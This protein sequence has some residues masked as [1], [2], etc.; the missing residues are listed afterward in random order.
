MTSITTLGGRLCRHELGDS[1]AQTHNI[2]AGF[3]YHG[4][5]ATRFP[6]DRTA[7]IVNKT[8]ER[9]W[10]YSLELGI[11]LVPEH[12]LSTRTL[13]YFFSCASGS[14]HISA[15]CRRGAAQASSSQAKPP[16]SCRPELSHPPVKHVSMTRQK[17]TAESSAFLMVPPFRDH[18]YRLYCTYICGSATPFHFPY[19][20]ILWQPSTQRN[21]TVKANRNVRLE[22]IR[23]FLKLMEARAR[24]STGKSPDGPC[25]YALFLMFFFPVFGPLLPR[26]VGVPLRWSVSLVASS[27]WGP[28]FSFSCRHTPQRCWPTP[29]DTQTGNARMLPLFLLP[30]GAIATVLGVFRKRP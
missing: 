9:H 5:G 12:D 2:G 16:N 8:P 27:S 4:V 29:P 26:A 6:D 25:A 3:A 13:S 7:K 23:I 14:L 15:P 22:A 21:T 19:I 18:R 28:I 11:I 10:V 20:I 24:S 17:M 1:D 30:Y